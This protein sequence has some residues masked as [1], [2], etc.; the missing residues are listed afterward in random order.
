MNDVE[1]LRKWKIKDEL[2]LDFSF[3]TEIK[4]KD[5]LF[6]FPLDKIRDNSKFLYLNEPKSEILLIKENKEDLENFLKCFI[7]EL[8]HKEKISNLQEIIDLCLHYNFNHSLINYFI[9]KI[10]KQEKSLPHLYLLKSVNLCSEK[11]SEKKIIFNE[12][13]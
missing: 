9:M 13:L 2:N 10:H 3:K 8:L 4:F 7:D 6:L 11:L 5:D 1:Y 12:Y